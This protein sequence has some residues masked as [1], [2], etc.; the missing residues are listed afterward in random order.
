MPDRR[1]R[2]GEAGVRMPDRRWR[3]GEA[4][5][6]MPDQNGAGS[7][8]LVHPAGT[9]GNLVR[10]CALEQRDLSA[11]NNGEGIGQFLAERLA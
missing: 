4:S 5:V 1:W 2:A 8:W 11:A 7:R 9:R 10:I 6:R 3:A